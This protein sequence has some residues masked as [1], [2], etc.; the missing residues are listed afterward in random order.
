[1]L[2]SFSNF[3]D[4]SLY[5]LVNDNEEA[6][7][8]NEIL[9]GVVVIL[10]SYIFSHFTYKYIEFPF[11]KVRDIRIIIALLFTSFMLIQIAHYIDKSKGL[12]KRIHIS[13][14]K[15][16]NERF[17]LIGSKENGIKLLSSVLGYEPENNGIKLTVDSVEN[18]KKLV[19]L[20]GDSHAWQLY[21]DLEYY[22]RNEGYDLLVISNTGDPPF[23][24]HYSISS[25]ADKQSLLKEIKKPDDIYKVLEYLNK[26][27]KL[28]K[29][30]FSI[31]LVAYYMG[32]DYGVLNKKQKNE[33]DL[34]IYPDY[35]NKDRYNHRVSFIK[36]LEFTFNYFNKMGYD[37]Y[38][39][40]DNPNLGF[41]SQ[42]Y[43]Y[44]PYYLNSV[45]GLN[46]FKGID[47]IKYD[48]YYE[49]EGKYYQKVFKLLEKY[50]KIK[51]IDLRDILCDKD[52]CYIV[53]DGLFLYRDENH[54]SI[55]GSFYVA[56]YILNN[57][58]KQK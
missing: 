18:I 30:V 42:V 28:E 4:N 37:F 25:K 27:G 49:K 15:I 21:E 35:L 32:Y 52:Y 11:R 38:F 17:N 31:R 44:R 57:L 3:F 36:A 14:T 39:V 20:I 50:P 10:I 8:L 54:L 16:F 2:L 24:K 56:P 40:I 29:V 7:L 51:I 9:K 22:L 19:V 5:Y 41:D 6:Y 43:S 12:E 55:E 58:L 13:F 53:K 26:K 23:Y 48:M 45:F 33:L 1:M 46:I 34:V 47:K